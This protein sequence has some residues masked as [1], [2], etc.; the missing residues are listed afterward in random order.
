MG[1]RF[2]STLAR[3]CLDSNCGNSSNELLVD[4]NG[5]SKFVWVGQTCRISRLDKGRVYDRSGFMWKMNS[6][7]DVD[8]TVKVNSLVN[9]RRRL[10]TLTEVT[11]PEDTKRTAILSYMSEKMDGV[12]HVVARLT[13]GHFYV[14]HALDITPTY[15]EQEGRKMLMDN[16]MYEVA[17]DGKGGTLRPSL[18]V[19]NIPAAFCCIELRCDIKKMCEDNKA[20]KRNLNSEENARW[21]RF[22]QS[23]GVLRLGC[24]NDVERILWL[25]QLKLFEV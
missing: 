22:V 13:A 16:E 9:W 23:G 17:F 11:G 21:N 10:F 2:G 19:Q 8:N 15:T 4:R 24:E 3:E 18:I 25:E 20:M 1:N 14:S 12:S 7:V 5:M 6:D